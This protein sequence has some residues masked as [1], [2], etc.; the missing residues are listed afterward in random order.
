MEHI[1][2]ILDRTI[3][4]IIEEDADDVQREAEE[5]LRLLKARRSGRITSEQEPDA[6]PVRNDYSHVIR[7]QAAPPEGYGLTGGTGREL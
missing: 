6:Y 5:A 1:A 7:V 3:K 4:S 2:S